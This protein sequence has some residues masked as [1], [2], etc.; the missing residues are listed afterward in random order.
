MW[1]MSWSMPTERSFSLSPL[2]LR[3]RQPMEQDA[4][5][6][7]QLPAT[8]LSVN[9]VSSSAQHQVRFGVS[10]AEFLLLQ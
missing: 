10:G 9:P 4:R 3:A 2:L 8:S 7:P 1:S 6:P 5:C